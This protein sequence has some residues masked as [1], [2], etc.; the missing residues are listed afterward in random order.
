MN[1]VA[2]AQCPYRVFDVRLYLALQADLLTP[3]APNHVYHEKDI[4]P[5][6]SIGYFYSAG[7][8]AMRTFN[9]KN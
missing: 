8:A 1:G 3:H 5:L 2:P 4:T 9:G 7:C 6:S